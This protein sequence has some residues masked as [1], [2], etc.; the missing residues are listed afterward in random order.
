[1][2]IRVNNRR[3]HADGDE[4][5]LGWLHEFASF[6]TSRFIRVGRRTKRVSHKI[7]M[8]NL[9]SG[10]FP[11]GLLSLIEREAPNKGIHLTVIDER[12]FKPH[13]KPDDVNLGWLYWYQKEAVETALSEVR[14]IIKAPTGS[15]KTEIAAA[16]VLSVPCKWLF[17]VHRK[18]LVQDFVD[19]F[20]LRTGL[21]ASIFKRGNLDTSSEVQVCTFQTLYTALKAKDPH[22]QGLIKGAEGLIIDECHVQPADSHYKVTMAAENAYYRIGLSG[23]PFAR[24][25]KKSIMA[26]SVLGEK[27]YEIKTE[28]L[29]KEGVLAKPDIYMVPIYQE[30]D[31]ATYQGVYGECIVRSTKRNKTVVDCVEQARKPCVVF[32]KEIKHGK[33]LLKRL[34]RKEIQAEFVWGDIKSSEQRKASVR[35]LEYGD[36]DVIIANVV[37]QEGVDIP[38]LESVVMA[39]GGKSAISTLQKIGR[40][41]RSDQ[42]RKQTFQVFDI[43]DEGN[44]WLTKH[45]SARIKTYE[46]EGHKVIILDN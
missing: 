18:N 21:Q 42:G 16:L 33:D 3:S 25:D 38:T 17:I 13:F 40:G 41:M 34:E 8:F 23:T 22:A 19:R 36:I 26:I 31:K 5:E 28:T 35:R 39:A 2:I 27:I 24:G 7:R 12:E 43:K 10:Y 11:T 44:K 6:E 15:G 20:E 30:S 37:F 9:L 46:S 29:I 1:M 14:G 45:S 32:V 4:Q